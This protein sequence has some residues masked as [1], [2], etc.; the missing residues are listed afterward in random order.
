MQGCGN[1]LA[2][3]VKYGAGRRWV[4]RVEVCSRGIAPLNAGVTG[5]GQRGSVI[6]SRT[7]YSNHVFS[8]ILS[9]HALR[10]SN[11][12][13]VTVYPINRE[14]GRSL[15]TIYGLGL[16]RKRSS[17][18]DLIPRIGIDWLVRVQFLLAGSRDCD[19]CQRQ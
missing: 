5:L 11:P 12:D 7:I 6:L 9:A 14:T 3:D 1:A 10:G 17:E 8:R 2:T 15:F 18:N 19:R 13:L 16:P 4:N